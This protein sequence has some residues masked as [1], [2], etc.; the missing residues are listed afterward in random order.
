MARLTAGGFAAAGGA[1]LRWPVY[2]FDSNTSGEKP[3]EEFFTADEDL[4]L[5]RFVN[6]GVVKN[7]V[8]RQRTDIDVLFQALRECFR[9]P[10]VAKAD[11]VAVLGTFLP[12]FA[13]IETGKGL[14]QKM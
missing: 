4:D 12:H 5:S 3:Y 8:R 7:A 6:L 11:I 14:D 9:R 13:H 10:N 1:P 2:F